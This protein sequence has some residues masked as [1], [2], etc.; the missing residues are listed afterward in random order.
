MK[1]AIVIWNLKISGGG[2]RQA[3]ELAKYLINEK[4]DVK[5]YCAYLSKENCYPDLI[6]NFNIHSLYNQ[7]RYKQNYTPILNLF[8]RFFYPLEPLFCLKQGKKIVNLMDKD[9]DIVNCHES[10]AHRV[11][12]IYKKRYR[13]PVVWMLNDLQ[14]H[15][16]IPRID[17][18]FKSLLKF[19]LFP[20]R[21]GLIGRYLDKNC[22]AKIDQIVVLDRMNKNL[23]KE[24]T[25]FDANIIRSGVDIGNFKYKKRRSNLQ[26]SEFKILVTGIFFPHRR[27]E[28][29]I[30]ALNILRKEGY[31]M[32]LNII[33]TD[34]CDKAYGRKIRNLVS[35]L[36]IEGYVNFLGTVSERELIRHYSTS[37]V[38][39]FPNHPQTWG[40]AVFEAMACG[41][42]V[43]VSTGCGASEVLTDGENTLLVPPESP[44]EIASCLRKLFND[45]KLYEHLSINGRKFVEENIRWDLYGKKMLQLF[46]EVLG[47]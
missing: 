44:E 18:N 6:K 37:D 7:S 35:A 26:Q 4:H 33:G 24:N 47:Y 25:N 43:I 13:V 42:P 5:I 14:S 23:L 2:Q 17:R 41:T 32:K 3:L 8:K 45:Q 30:I 10:P 27:F 9:F 21:G 16:K 11:G 39:V 12:S 38:F 29:L 31:N 22:V 15:L 46:S 19:F 36:N 1:I 20:I 28:D 34:V 40:L